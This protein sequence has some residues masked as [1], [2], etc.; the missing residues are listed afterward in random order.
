MDRWPVDCGDA[1][2]YAISICYAL[3]DDGLP[4]KPGMPSHS[5]SRRASR[6][7]NSTVPRDLLLV[8]PTDPNRRARI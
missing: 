4:T 6:F 1:H 8:T 7:A 2:R 3:L 5:R